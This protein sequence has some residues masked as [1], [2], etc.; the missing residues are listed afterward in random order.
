MSGLELE[1]VSGWAWARAT[2][3]EVR[4]PDLAEPELALAEAGLASARGLAWVREPEV[5]SNSAF[6][7]AEQGPGA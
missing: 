6:V 5:A 4:E 2:D 7:A 1:P 3:L